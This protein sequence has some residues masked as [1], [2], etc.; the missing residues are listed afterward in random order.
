MK[1]FAPAGHKKLSANAT[2]SPCFSERS[3]YFLSYKIHNHIRQ[4]ATHHYES[5]II[6][7]SPAVDKIATDGTLIDIFLVVHYVLPRIR[8]YLI[9]HIRMICHLSMQV[10]FVDDL[11]AFQ[12][13]RSEP[14]GS[15]RSS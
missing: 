6:W 9:D 13:F 1:I 15:I 2:I 11:L 8:A 7:L 14:V 3:L 5:Y 4:W 12:Y 10:F